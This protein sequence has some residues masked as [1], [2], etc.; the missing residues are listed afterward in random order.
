MPRGPFRQQ[1][2]LTQ[3]VSNNWIEVKKQEQFG[4][5]D[6]KSLIRRFVV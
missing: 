1:L 2:L 5:L 6:N 4:V 3:R